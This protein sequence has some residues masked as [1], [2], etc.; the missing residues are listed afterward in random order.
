MQLFC[1]AI[2]EVVKMIMDATKG[3]VFLMPVI[4]SGSKLPGPYIKA[5]TNFR[6][7]LIKVKVF[8]ILMVL[9]LAIP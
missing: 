9:I 6:L 5:V 8:L 7:M 2:A 4:F 1:C 3:N